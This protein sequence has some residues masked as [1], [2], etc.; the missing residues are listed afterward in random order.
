MLEYWEWPFVGPLQITPAPLQ[1]ILDLMMKP[2][3]QAIPESRQPS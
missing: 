1:E 2:P 3:D